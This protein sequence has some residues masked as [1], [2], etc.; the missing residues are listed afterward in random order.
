MKSEIA[1]PLDSGIM[2][3]NIYFGVNEDNLLWGKGIILGVVELAN[4]QRA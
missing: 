4:G 2:I 1:Y 3:V